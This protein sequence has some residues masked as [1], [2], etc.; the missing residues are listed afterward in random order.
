[1]RVPDEVRKC[2]VFVGL[3]V[4]GPGGRQSFR[5]L[6][7][8]FIVSVPSESIQG[9]QYLYLITAKHVAVNLKNI[10]LCVK[11][12]KKDG[13]SD[14]LCEDKVNWWYH[15]TDELVDVAVIP[16]SPPET[17]EFRA[18]PVNILLKDEVIQNRNIGVGDE[19]FITGLFTPLSRSAKNMPIV[20]MGSIAMI[21]DEPVPINMNDMEVNV[22]AYLIE[23]RSLSGLSGSPAF[24][25]R[26]ARLSVRDEFYLLGLTMGHWVI[27]SKQKRDELQMDN[28]IYSKLNTG[29]AIVVPAAKILEVI[30][31]PE[32][33]E[34][35]KK[36]DEDL[37]SLGGVSSGGQAR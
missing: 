4:R 6:G 33:V 9:A 36:R 25:R 1:M 32:L 8:A 24:V 29:I 34:M 16:W 37:S 31:R 2:V 12:N 20:R 19:V 26:S 5:V 11:V 17:V 22:E 7:T 35:R 28:D 21:P 18:V 23:A 27:P 13:N 15:P 3:M 14:F 30:N 10:S